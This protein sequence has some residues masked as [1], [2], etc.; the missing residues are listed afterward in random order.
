MISLYYFL[1]GRYENAETYLSPSAEM[2][3]PCSLI[4]Y[5]TNDRSPKGQFFTFTLMFRAV[6]QVNIRVKLDMRRNL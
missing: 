1:A 6:S 2:Y 4:N 5:A 3:Y